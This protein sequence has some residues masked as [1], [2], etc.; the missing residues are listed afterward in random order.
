MLD[1][2]DVERP[3]LLDQVDTDRTT[4]QRLVAVVTR[5]GFV[6]SLE[7]TARGTYRGE[8][9]RVRNYFVI[10]GIDETGVARPPWLDEALN[11]TR[12]TESLHRVR[13]CEREHDAV[14]LLGHD[15]ATLD[16]FGEEW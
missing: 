2:A 6:R 15:M 14:V 13:E 12:E 11:A 7:L 9:V 5:Q 10:T 16:R 4:Q 1:A 3:R 8:P